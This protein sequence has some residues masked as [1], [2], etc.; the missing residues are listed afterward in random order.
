MALDLV[1]TNLSEKAEAG[2][3]FELKMPGTDEPLGA[4]ITVRGTESPKVKAY[5]KKVFRE[6]QLK[7]TQAKRKGREPDQMTIEDAEDMAIE[8]ALVRMIGWRGIE[9]DEKEVKFSDENVRRILR[10]HGWIRQQ[11]TD[12]SDL[13][14]NFI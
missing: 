5:G 11:I 1:K 10:E 8:S 13:I 6:M 4:F 7:E 9:E 3:E 2:Y 12:E 14:S